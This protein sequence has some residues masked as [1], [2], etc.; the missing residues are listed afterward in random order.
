MERTALQFADHT[1]LALQ[2][3]NSD[4]FASIPEP[5]A[6]ARPA[7]GEKTKDHAPAPPLKQQRPAVRNPAARLRPE[8][9]RALIRASAQQQQHVA[10]PQQQR[11]GEAAFANPRLTAGW[12]PKVPLGTAAMLHAWR[13]CMASRHACMHAGVDCQCRAPVSAQ[14][15]A[16]PLSACVRLH[17]RHD[18]G[19]ACHACR[20]MRWRQPATTSW[21][22]RCPACARVRASPC[23]SLALSR[24]R[25]RTACHR[26]MGLDGSRVPDRSSQV[27]APHVSLSQAVGLREGSRWVQ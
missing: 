19:H 17:R 26:S 13:Q 25:H 22:L 11:A 10:Q 3:S 2:K 14:N 4:R 1:L 6:Y 5:P 20:W 24:M 7:L 23:R 18:G 27:Q 12:T 9:A 8:V 16:E 21:R 15:E